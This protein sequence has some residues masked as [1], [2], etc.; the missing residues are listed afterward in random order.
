MDYTLSGAAKAT[1]K[2]KTTL[3]RAIK[4]GKLSARRT[5]EGAYLIDAAEL[6]RAF[7]PEP[8][9][10]SPWDNTERNDAPLEGGGTELAVLRVRAE[11]LEAQLQREREMVDDLR[12]RLDRAEERVLALMVEPTKAATSAGHPTGA[13]ASVTEFAAS[14]MSPASQPRRGVLARLFGRA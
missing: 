13:P 10:P 11:M 12:R 4:T 7:P 9:A 1:G 8:A 2:A 14:T 6:A 5:E 3:H